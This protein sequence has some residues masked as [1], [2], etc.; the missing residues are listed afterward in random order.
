MM[1]NP[2]QPSSV[3]KSGLRKH[4]MQRRFPRLSPM[5]NQAETFWVRWLSL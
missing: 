2:R 4:R 1:Q 3:H 5:E